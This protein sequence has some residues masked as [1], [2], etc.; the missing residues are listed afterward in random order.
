MRSAIVALAALASSVSAVGN[1]IVKNNCPSTFYLWSVGG[2]IGP[3]V[4]VAPGKNYTEVLRRDPTSGGVALKITRTAG[5]LFTG[6]PTQIFSYTLD[7][8]Q[9]WY[10]LSTVFG[11]PFAGSHLT[12]TANGGGTIDWP[13]GTHPGGSQVKVAPSGSN[14]VFTACA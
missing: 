6:A 11:E 1:A 14:V 3:E 10:D 9:V 12:V 8:A 4:A 13:Q 7:G 2:S 5:G